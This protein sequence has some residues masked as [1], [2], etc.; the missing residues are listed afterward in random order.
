MQYFDLSH[1]AILKISGKDA[2][3]FLNAQ[4]TCDLAELDHRDWLFTAWCLPNGRAI[5]TF[6][7]FRQGHEYYMMLPAMLRDKVMQ[8]LSMY[9]LR[10]DV[11]ITDCSDDITL[12]GLAGENAASLIDNLHINGPATLLKLQGYKPRYIICCPNDIV[13]DVMQPVSANCEEADRSGWSI[14]DIE[15]GLA[16]IINATS[17]MYLPQ[18]LNLDHIAGLSYKKG[19]YPG[20]EVI[21]R[22]HFRGKLKKRLFLGHADASITPGPGDRIETGEHNNA[23]D[24]IDAERY[25]EG[26]LC[27]L[28]VID[29]AHAD[30]DNLYIRNQNAIPV[31]IAAIEYPQQ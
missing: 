6:I 10:S 18:M 16:W 27:F 14:L 3:V 26:G 15:A 29:L 4:F 12:L 24:V 23:G 21:S 11:R 28:A 17:E 19:C 25:P 7:L 20:Q 2:S 8:R 5:T 13:G 9:V 31:H 1:F 22:L 30:A